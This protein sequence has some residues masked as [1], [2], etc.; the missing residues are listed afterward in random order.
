VVRVNHLPWFTLRINGR[1]NTTWTR[2]QVLLGTMYLAWNP[3]RKISGAF[4][5]VHTWQCTVWTRQR[6]KLVV[7]IGHHVWDLVDMCG[8]SK[9][10]QCLWASNP[11]FQWSVSRCR[12]SV[13]LSCL[14]FRGIPSFLDALASSC[15]I[16]VVV[17]VV[18]SFFCKSRKRFLFELEGE[19][20]S[21]GIWNHEHQICKQVSFL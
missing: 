8:I 18:F 7:W 16:L 17:V 5:R 21:L 15:C 13:A 4:Y 10:V 19:L 6:P 2:T 11:N 20:S 9:W 1:V 12:V 3:T 14:E